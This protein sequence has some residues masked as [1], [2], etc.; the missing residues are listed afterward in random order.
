MKNGA[1]RIGWHNAHQDLPAKHPR[2]V[3]IN[4]ALSIAIFSSWR[5]LL[6]IAQLRMRRIII[7]FRDSSQNWCGR[8]TETYNF[9]AVA[10][11]VHDYVCMYNNYGV[12]GVHHSSVVISR[13][14]HTVQSTLILLATV[15]VI[16]NV[17]MASK[18]S[19][20]LVSYIN[21]ALECLP[22]CFPMASL[23]PSVVP[24]SICSSYVCLG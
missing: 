18:A 7:I 6:S 19:Q 21:M 8:W 22:N 14:V 10:L 13:N 12:W 24:W 9:I 17:C 15:E 2:M 20:L 23:P 16:L 1:V 11:C 5:A 4:A 3:K